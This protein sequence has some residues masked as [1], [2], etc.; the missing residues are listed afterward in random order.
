MDQDDTQTPT[1]P[2][3]RRP[4]SPIHLVH[5]DHE[6]GNLILPNA[7]DSH[8]L[9]FEAEKNRLKW[10]TRRG[11]D[12]GCSFPNPEY[13]DTI[14]PFRGFPLSQLF[15]NVVP[16]QVA[17]IKN[18]PDRHLAVVPFD[19]GPAFIKDHPTFPHDVEAFMKSFRYEGLENITCVWAEAE[20]KPPG[21]NKLY[22][23]P[24]A[25]I[26][27]NPTGFPEDFHREVLYQGT[28]AFSET[29]AFSVMEFDP[30]YLFS[31]ILCNFTGPS[32]ADSL[33]RNDAQQINTA[34][35][36]IK[37]VLRNTNAFFNLVHRLVGQG[38]ESTPV[39]VYQNTVNWMNTLTLQYVETRN[40]HVPGTAVY[41]LTGLP[42]AQTPED[43]A[44][45]CNIIR[46]A[47]YPMAGGLLELKPKH[48]R[49]TCAHCKINTH[50]A[51]ACPSPIYLAGEDHAMRNS[52]RTH[53]PMRR[54]EPQPTTEAAALVDTAVG[55]AV[56]PVV[57]V[58]VADTGD[59]STLV[60][61]VP[62]TRPSSATES[63]LLVIL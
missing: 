45:M 40:P 17:A 60:V 23:K 16:R 59:M 35:G 31:P 48:G 33:I 25:L 34:L 32:G 7:Y 51:H 38:E 41:Q 5:I 36:T 58:A 12:P 9:P 4:P 27:Y 20:S 11:P 6:S 52:I 47:S 62:I 53:P 50:P 18:A 57:E 44:L 42:I 55:L 29:F 2:R 1:R 56:G 8:G 37:D 13:T 10:F 28:Y 63:L 15:D 54:L 21:Y 39:A 19:A 30:G 3:T 61:D 43:H 14:F 26:V 49:L 24:W 22:G 46:A